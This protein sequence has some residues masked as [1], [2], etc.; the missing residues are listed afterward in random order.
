MTV[1]CYIGIGSNLGRR[2]RNIETAIKEL[3]KFGIRVVKVS[4]IYETEPQGGPV[5]GKFLNCCAR[6]K[7]SHNPRDLLKIFKT[8][9]KG[10]GRLRGA[11]F[12]PR[13]ID[14]D[15]LLYGDRRINRRDLKVPH[16]RMMA[17][18]FVL[19]PLSEIANF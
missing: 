7:T 13:V 18:D 8:I 9:E 1:T 12:G 11:R 10:M 14:L 5:Q 19:L 3:Q 17:R 6:I 15:I 4:G 16:P 2:R